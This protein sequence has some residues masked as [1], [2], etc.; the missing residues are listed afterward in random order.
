MAQTVDNS[1]LAQT[2]DIDN[3][4]DPSDVAGDKT[5]VMETRPRIAEPTAAA[6]Q[7]ATEA[8]TALL[9]RQRVVRDRYGGMYW[10]A[11]F[12][13]FAVAT[14]CTIVLLGVVAAILS[15]ATFHLSTATPNLGV[16][17]SGSTHGL[18][19]DALVG[20]LVAVFLGYL[21]GGYTASRMARFD[22]PQNGIGVWMWTILAT[23]VFGILGAIASGGLYLSNQIRLDPSHVT[24]TAAAGIAIVVVLAVML[25]GA[26]LGAA[27]GQRYHRV[28]DRGYVN[29]D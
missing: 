8:R 10:G 11:D 1:E 14:F 24:V 27:I 23:L 6:P 9:E 26:V 17:V 4:I 13:G 2:T 16:Q 21:I 12:I 5:V 18:G 19:L 15:L 3:A 22:G 29:A 20:A 25:V 7:D 28:I